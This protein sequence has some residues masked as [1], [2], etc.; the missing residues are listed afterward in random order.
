MSSGV[1]QL[2][3]NCLEVAPNVSQKSFLYSGKTLSSNPTIC[4]FRDET[5]VTML[6]LKRV[7]C[8]KDNKFSSGNL[9]SLEPKN[10]K[11]KA[12]RQ[13]TGAYYKKI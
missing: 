12:G 9:D 8:F 11:S 4:I 1:E 3:N 5:L 10:I 2:S 13:F 7:S 6:D